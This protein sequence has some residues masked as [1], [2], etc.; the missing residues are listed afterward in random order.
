MQLDKQNLQQKQKRVCLT[1]QGNGPPSSNNALFSD[2]TSNRADEQKTNKNHKDL[3][4]TVLK[5][6]HVC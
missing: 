5:T 6:M 4:H 3:P 1:M 2:A